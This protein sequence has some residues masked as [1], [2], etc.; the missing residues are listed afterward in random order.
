MKNLILLAATAFLILA[1]TVTSNAGPNQLYP[2]DN[3]W[4]YSDRGANGGGA[5]GSGG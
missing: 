3:S 5:G 2:Q 1:G 4:S